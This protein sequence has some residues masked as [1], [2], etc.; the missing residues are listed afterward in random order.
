M[1]TAIFSALLSTALFLSGSPAWTKAY[2]PSAREMIQKAEFI[3][4]VS[5]DEP[6]QQEVKGSWTYGEATDARLNKSIKGS[7]PSKFKIH[8]REDFRCAQC[9]FPKGESLVFLRKD[10]DL[11]VGQ[12]WGI[13][14]LPVKSGQVDWFSDLNLRVSDAKVSL[15]DCIKQIEAESK[16]SKNSKN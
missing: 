15:K 10:H 4:L 5:L 12:A 1:K 14:C 16:N 9:H 6:V 13:S 8:G 2:Y 11:Y 3:A 7:L